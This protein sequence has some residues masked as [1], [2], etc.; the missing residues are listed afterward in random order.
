MRIKVPT[1]HKQN[2][3]GNHRCDTSPI[4][5]DIMLNKQSIFVVIA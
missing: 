2:W 3:G 5:R 4:H 1:T